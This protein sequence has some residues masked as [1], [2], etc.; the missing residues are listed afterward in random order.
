MLVMSGSPIA[1]SSL[2]LLDAGS[3]TRDETFVALTGSRLGASFVVLVVAFIYALRSRGPDANR[4][5]TL[6]VGILALLLTA[7]AYVPGR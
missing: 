3:L 7:V 5:A 2:A 1:A 4:G 6:S